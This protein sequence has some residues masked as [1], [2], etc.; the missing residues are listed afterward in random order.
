MNEMVSTNEA[1]IAVPRSLEEFRNHLLGD[2]PG[3]PSGDL[4]KI[5]S[6]AIAASLASRH[7]QLSND[8]LPFTDPSR[9][10]L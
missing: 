8:E 5:I 6:G 4:V 3:L 2:F 7:A 1:V 9:W 10:R